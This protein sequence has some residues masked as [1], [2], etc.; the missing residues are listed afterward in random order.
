M[1]PELLELQ[2]ELFRRSQD[3]ISDKHSLGPRRQQYVQSYHIRRSGQIYAHQ[4]AQDGQ[5]GIRGPL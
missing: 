2:A 4:R 3:L 1:P 5:T